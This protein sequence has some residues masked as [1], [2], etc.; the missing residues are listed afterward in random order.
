M[1]AYRASRAKPWTAPDPFHGDYP[2]TLRVE[3]DRHRDNGRPFSL[4]WGY[5]L[6]EHPPPEDWKST[7]AFM[8]THFQSAYERDDSKRGRFRAPEPEASAVVV[9]PAPV[10][11]LTAG[12]QCQSPDGC[13][14]VATRGRFGPTWC[15]IHGAELERL[16]LSDGERVPALVEAA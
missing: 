7:V 2:A 9:H 11:V 14:R 13:A 5:A 6:T 10:P 1:K 3:L 16:A 12:R 4:A 15:D 8:R